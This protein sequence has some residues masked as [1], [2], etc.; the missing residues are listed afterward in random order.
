MYSSVSMAVAMHHHTLELS[1]CIFILFLL[2]GGLCLY[3]LSEKLRGIFRYRMLS[4]NAVYFSISGAVILLGRTNMFRFN[5]PKEAAKLR[6]KRKVRLNQCLVNLNLFTV[7]LLVQTF[8]DHCRL[9]FVI[10]FTFLS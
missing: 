2:S 3:S 10:C 8:L 5:H 1:K 4:V 6:E 7:F 9:R